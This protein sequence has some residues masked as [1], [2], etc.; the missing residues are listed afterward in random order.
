M[1]FEFANV[2]RIV[3]GPGRVKEMRT[4]APAMGK[5]ALVACG[6]TVRAIERVQPLFATLTNAGLEYV[7]LAVS[8]EPTIELVR[9][10]TKQARVERCDMVIGFG[11]GSILDAGKAI[12]ALMT[13]DGDPLDYI[14]VIGKGEAL[15]HPSAPFIA[16]P[17]TAGTGSEVTRNAVLG[18]PEHRVKV[19]LRSPHMLPRVALIDPELTYQLPPEIT[20]ATGL[21]ALTQ[22]IEAFVSIKANPLTDAM[23]REG[24]YRVARS[25]RRAY[26][27]AGGLPWREDWQAIAVAR[28]D[29]C[30]AAML[31]GMALANAALGAAHGLSGPLGGMFEAPHGALCAAVLP[32]VVEVNE[33]AARERLVGSPVIPRFEQVRRA[34]GDLR[35]LV[36]ALNIPPLRTHGVSRD[37]FPEIIEK[38][39]ASNSMK[40]NPV[41]LEDQELREILEQAL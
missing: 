3:F 36:Q 27:A 32:Y 1:N 25:L 17:T 11:G 13:N 4:I 16:V 40:G 10:G 20:A 18:S 2:P 8:A 6:H 15:A 14:E 5:R 30:V 19:S 26:E 29:M 12:A 39:K 24:M 7:A 23:C 9:E 31:S 35:E 28:E 37:R 38:A 34:V 33:R 41:V 22:L 21:D